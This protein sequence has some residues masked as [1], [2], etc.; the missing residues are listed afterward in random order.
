MTSKTTTTT[1]FEVAKF[2][3]KSNFLLWKMRVM[4]LL[5]KESIHKALLGAEKLLKMGD[6]EWNDI[7]FRDKTTI[8]LCLSYEVFYNVMNNEITTGLWCRLE[9][10]TWQSLSKKLFMKKQLYMLRMKEGTPILQYLSVFNKILSDL[11]AL[12][13]KLEEDKT[14]LLLFSFSSSYDH[15]TTTIMYSKKNLEL[16]DVWQILQNELMKKIDST[17]EAL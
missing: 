8:I 12:E 2:D 5:V 9:S 1:K 4:T 11:V 14:F 6:D 3:G 15:L 7:D 13:V 10:F 17:E 16:E